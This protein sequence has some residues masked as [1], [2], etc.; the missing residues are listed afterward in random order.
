MYIVFVCFNQKQCYML[1]VGNQ[2]ISYI[3]EKHKEFIIIF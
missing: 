1:A 3:V 2:N